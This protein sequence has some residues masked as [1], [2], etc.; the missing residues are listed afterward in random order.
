[1]S[2]FTVWHVSDAGRRRMHSPGALT[3]IY[4]GT[5]VLQGTPEHE[6]EAGAW[7]VAVSTYVLRRRGQVRWIG[8]A[9][10]LA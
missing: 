2:D 10:V 3:G 6:Y 5:L 9:E 7:C 8:S 4:A 1:V